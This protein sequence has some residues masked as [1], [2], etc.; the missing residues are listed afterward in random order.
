MHD[1]SSKNDFLS[2]V[3]LPSLFRVHLAR[4]NMHGL[5]AMGSTFRKGRRMGNPPTQMVLVIP[6]SGRAVPIG[7]LQI[8]A[9]REFRNGR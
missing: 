6:F 1:V 5:L 2:V 3:R 9:P 4:E 7:L 8:L